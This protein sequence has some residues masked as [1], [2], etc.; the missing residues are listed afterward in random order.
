MTNVWTSSQTPKLSI[1][2]APRKVN[3]FCL[4]TFVTASLICKGGVSLILWLFYLHRPFLLIDCNLLS[5]GSTIFFVI[6]VI[7]DCNVIRRRGIFFAS[8]VWIWWQVDFDWDKLIALRNSRFVS[9]SD[10]HRSIVNE[11][12]TIDKIEIRSRSGWNRVRWI[13]TY[14]VDIQGESDEVD[15]DEQ[16]TQEKPITQNGNE[17]VRQ[18]R[19]VLNLGGRHCRSWPQ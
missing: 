5:M 17:N 1:A 15:C 9:R 12:R 6:P 18:W 7:G 2:R 11:P 10:C 4:E 16:T 19:S 14:S 8:D 3:W 13:S